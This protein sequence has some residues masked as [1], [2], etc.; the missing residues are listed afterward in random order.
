MLQNRRHIMRDPIRG[1]PPI[2]TTQLHKHLRKRRQLARLALAA[3]IVLA[4][5]AGQILLDQ[6]LACAAGELVEGDLALRVWMRQLGVDVRGGGIAQEMRVQRLVVDFGLEAE[7]HG[8]ALAFV[9][10]DGH[11]RGEFFV[12]VERGRG[13]GR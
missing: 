12:E 11:G 4:S 9:G 5:C 13:G 8:D 3:R 6:R 2:R 1:K 10:G 7:R